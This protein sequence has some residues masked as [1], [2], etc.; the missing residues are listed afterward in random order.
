MGRMEYR[1]KQYSVRNS[2]EGQTMLTGVISDI[3]IYNKSKTCFGMQDIT[4]IG[5]LGSPF[6]G[7]RMVPQLAVLAAISSPFWKVPL[8]YASRGVLAGVQPWYLAVQG[9]ALMCSTCRFL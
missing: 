3:N 7:H 4:A 2:S 5:S 1:A 6:L 8:S 9:D